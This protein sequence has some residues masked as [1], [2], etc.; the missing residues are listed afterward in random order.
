MSFF[1]CGGIM[2][3]LVI[4]T[5]GEFEHP[6][7]IVYYLVDDIAAAHKTL[8]ERGVTF[9]EVPNFVANM[10]DQD[11]WKG[12]F[13]DTEGSILAIRSFVQMGFFQNK[14][15]CFSRVVASA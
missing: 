3:T 15:C 1:D 12:F 5:S 13:Q 2:L 4:P 8:V 9:S 11:L 7:S 10:G 6:S 14:M